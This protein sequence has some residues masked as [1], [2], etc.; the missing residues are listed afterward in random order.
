[1]QSNNPILTRVEVSSDYAQPMS[2]QG[3]IQ[4]SVLLTLIAAVVG[5]GL[6]F[7]TEAVGAGPRKLMD[8]GG[9]GMA[10]AEVFVNQAG[11][12]NATMNSGVTNA[13]GL[14]GNAF[15]GA[16]GN[17]G[18][19]ISAGVGNLQHNGLAIATASCGACAP[20][21]PRS[22]WRSSCPRRRGRPARRGPG[23]RL[24]SG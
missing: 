19:N 17:I 9:F 1:M 10:D 16:S 6:S 20:P 24:R 22:S 18:V 13:A 11:F 3:A 4:K 12:G 23:R 5:I 21:P 7:F 15:G 14:S 2:V 8:I